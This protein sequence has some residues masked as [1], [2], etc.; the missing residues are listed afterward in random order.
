M[1]AAAAE[2]EAVAGAAGAEMTS[3]HAWHKI[4]YNPRGRTK[5]RQGTEDQRVFDGQTELGPNNLRELR[6]CLLKSP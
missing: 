2:A 1:A 4:E 6:F 3:Q 5:A